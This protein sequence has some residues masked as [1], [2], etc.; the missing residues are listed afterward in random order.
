VFGDE[1]GGWISDDRIRRRYT[2]ALAA[3][4]LRPLRFHDLRHTFGSLAITRADIV[5]VQ[6]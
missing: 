1:L 5:E 6:A 3:A 2:A 4:Q